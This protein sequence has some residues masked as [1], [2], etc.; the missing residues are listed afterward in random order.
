METLAYLASIFIGISLSL[1]GG[2]GS[3]LTVPV[4]VYLFGISP[5]V[6]TSY[7]LFIVGSTSLV[8]AFTNYRKGLVNVKTATLFGLT[9]I[10]TVFL[11]RKLLIPLIPNSLFHLGNFTITE[12]LLTMILFAIL[13]VAASVGMIR[14][15]TKKPGCLTCNLKGNLIRL[16]LSGIGIGL[17]TGLLGAGGGFLLIPTLVLFLGMPMRE[18]VGTSLL[19]IALNS[20][21]GFL[22]DLGHFTIDWLFL[23]KVTTVAISGIVLGTWLS[24][25]IKSNQLK[26]GFGWF[27]LAMGVFI[28]TKELFSAL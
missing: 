1:I 17:T 12:P 26:E 5:L 28:I 6:S 4:L 25:R 8:G 20:L 7:S 18:A 27:V 10:T 24:K 16:L 19:I 3:I 21:I 23:S 15:K 9:S 13:M 14:D 11:T 2:G 22:G